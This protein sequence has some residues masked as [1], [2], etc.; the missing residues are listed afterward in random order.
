MSAA[1]QTLVDERAALQVYLQDL[2]SAAA[3]VAD[4][5]PVQ[6]ES[7]GVVA[8]HAERAPFQCLLFKTAGLSL[9]LPL[10]ELNGILAW[11]QTVTPLPGH[12]SF[13]L[14]MTAQRG[15]Q[16][17]IIDI[18]QLIMPA[19][20]VFS[21]SERPRYLAL[22][23]GQQWGLACDS[24]AEVVTLDSH[25]VRWRARRVNQPWLAGTLVERLCALLDAEEL[26]KM[27]QGK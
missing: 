16:T 8:P 10:A 24:V 15:V 19:R 23:G 14:G 4:I 22:I 26:V 21:S 2:L 5:A 1:P 20:Y 13:F 7:S 18:A 3:P 27:L 11:P 12:A 6:I 17:K 25:Q 9:A